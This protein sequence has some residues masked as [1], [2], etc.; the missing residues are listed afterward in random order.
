MYLLQAI[1]LLQGRSIPSWYFYLFSW[2]THILILRNIYLH[3]WVFSENENLSGH[4]LPPDPGENKAF[5]R[6]GLSAACPHS[7]GSQ[8]ISVDSI[9]FLRRYFI[10]SLFTCCRLKE[11]VTHLA[12]TKQTKIKQKIIKWEW[13]KLP[14]N[15][16]NP[17]IYFQKRQ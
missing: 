17:R 14:S 7:R 11:I 8:Q 1:I 12:K 2:F 4:C 6:W 16:S 9:I 13:K 5:Q 10:S 15:N 3:K